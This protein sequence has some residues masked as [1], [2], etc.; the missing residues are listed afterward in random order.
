MHRFAISLTTVVILALGW[1]V[2]HQAEDPRTGG[3]SGRRPG[4]GI[5]E[6]RR[7]AARCASA[8][9]AGTETESALRG[10]GVGG[11]D[12]PGA[13]RDAPPI[14][15]TLIIAARADTASDATGAP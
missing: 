8:G 10:C 4:G 3:T 12:R 14:T 9:W 6:G 7:P 11:S 5:P 13:R 1:P 2:R 15:N